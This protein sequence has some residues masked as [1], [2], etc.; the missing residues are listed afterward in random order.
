MA[1]VA[2]VGKGG[3]GEVVGKA[4]PVDL[5]LKLAGKFPMPL[6]LRASVRWCPVVAGHEVLQVE[7]VA[8]VGVW[9]VGSRKRVR[10]W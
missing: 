5:G 1:R 6:Q 3:M 7:V 2:K 9:L 8:A 4:V 10:P